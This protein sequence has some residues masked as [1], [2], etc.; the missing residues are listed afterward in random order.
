[1]ATLNLQF[2]EQ[3]PNVKLSTSRFG[4]LVIRY[5]NSKLQLENRKH[6]KIS[7]KA[8]HPFFFLNVQ[9]TY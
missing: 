6:A 1:M 7:K 4:I 3:K 9:L 8:H 5:F 2:H